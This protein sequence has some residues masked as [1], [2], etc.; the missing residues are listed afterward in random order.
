MYKL[1]VVHPALEM[2]ALHLETVGGHL[3]AG[4]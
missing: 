2:S 4:T 3:V 1:E